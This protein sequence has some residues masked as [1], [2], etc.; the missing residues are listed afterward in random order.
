MYSAVFSGINGSVTD[1][2]NVINPIITVGIAGNLLPVRLVSAFSVALYGMFLAVFI[3]PARKN[4][5]VCGL[6]IV[7][8]LASYCATCLPGL[9]G[10]SEGTRTILLTVLISA[11]AAILF[12]RKQTGEETTNES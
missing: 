8:F 10:L 5:I 12:P 9:S 2:I 3:P 6:I 4:K 7:C 1:I 11:G